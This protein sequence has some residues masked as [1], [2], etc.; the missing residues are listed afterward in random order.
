MTVWLIDWKR[1]ENNDFAIAEEVTVAAANAKAHDKR[2][3]IVS[4]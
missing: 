4:S 2:P 3:D 1:P